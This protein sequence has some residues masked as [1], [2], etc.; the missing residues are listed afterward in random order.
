MLRFYD[1]WAKTI[2]E[3]EQWTRLGIY[4]RAE[5][6]NDQAAVH[7]IFLNRSSYAARTR[8]ECRTEAVC[9]RHHQEKMDHSHHSVP[10]H[11]APRGA[12][13]V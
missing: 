4:R 1:A 8:H 13:G 7:R 12:P 11:L 2:I 9:H 10:H 6:W 5:R 3:S